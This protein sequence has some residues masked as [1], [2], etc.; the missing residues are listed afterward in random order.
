MLQCIVLY[1][2]QA[3]SREEAASN[4]QRK[5]D[6]LTYKIKISVLLSAWVFSSPSISKNPYYQIPLLS[7][8]PTFKNFHISLGALI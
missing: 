8:L 4:T 1:F 6:S 7:L 3:V 5:K 2:N